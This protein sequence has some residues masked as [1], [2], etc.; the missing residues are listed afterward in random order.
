VTDVSGAVAL[1]P[2]TSR[3]NPSIL[4]DENPR[5]DASPVEQIHQLT[6]V[7]DARN[8]LG[9]TG[10]GIKVAVIDSGVYY[11]HPA[12]GGGFGPGY[13]VAFGYDLVG[14]S[15]GVHNSTLS[16]DSDPLDDC[17]VHSI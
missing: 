8:K 6:G 17:K 11:L 3:L 14:D 5:P 4:T 12:L 13:K 16:P 7:N 2:V 10:K 15:Y 1:H 9:L